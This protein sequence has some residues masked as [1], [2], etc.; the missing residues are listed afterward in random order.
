MIYGIRDA[1]DLI[2]W[3]K[4]TKRVELFV[5]Y[6]NAT[7]SEWT[8]ESVYATAKGSNAIRWDGARNGTLTL[9]TEVFDVGLLA[10]VMGS[11]IK[12]GRSDIMQ[13]EDGQ[14]DATRAIRLQGGH[15]LD[16]TSVAV[17]K[18][19]DIDDPSH[20]GEPLHNASAAAL[21]LPRQVK[22]V[23]VAMTD[24]TG[25]INFPRIADAKGYLVMRNGEIVSDT[26]TNEYTDTALTAE[27]VYQYT[28]RGYNDF[29][30]G[31]ISAVVAAT[32]S[33]TGVT[34]PVTFTATNAAKNE[35][36]SNTGEVEAPAAGV[37]T[38]SLVNG[39]VQFSE[40]AVIGD[41]YA[42]YYME[43]VENVRTLTI[44]ADK[45]ADNYE[46]FATATMRERDTGRD[47]LIQI[48]YYNA[49][50]QSN[51]TLTQ[52]ATEPTNLSIVFDLLPV[53]GALADF[54]IL[55]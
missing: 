24:T 5:N 31:P 2:L 29:G 55:P 51:F 6:A 32:A 49:K 48:R 43:K 54:H 8:S 42:V 15:A 11:E 28:V 16:P 39:V 47:E 22:D 46:I 38:Y 34:T 36:L 17:V 44:S 35:S 37:V 14:L 4:R 10:M 1:A 52:S 9:D 13:R 25:R 41:A 40:D 45:F 53:G 26:I 21:N 30:R 33:A 19:N 50:P 27:T 12:A 20:A 3:N 18:L 7:S 23:S